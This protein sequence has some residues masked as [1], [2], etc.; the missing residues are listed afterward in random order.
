PAGSGDVV[1]APSS[2]RIVLG[3]DERA[4]V[5][6]IPFGAAGGRHTLVVGAT[7]SGKTVTQTLIL[8][9]AIEAGH[10]AVVLDPK[11]DARM[12]EQLAAAAVHCGRE[13]LEWTPAGPNVYN[14][15]GHG[16]ASEIADRALAGER[17]T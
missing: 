10:G 13:F 11:G 15:F 14:P 4:R 17:F 3:R 12:R 1:R 5:V 6:S 8:C 7:G 2:E 16:S 9:R